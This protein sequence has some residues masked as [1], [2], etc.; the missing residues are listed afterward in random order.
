MPNPAFF[1]AARTTAYEF[2]HQPDY[3]ALLYTTD[4]A[5]L[6]QILDDLTTLIQTDWQDKVTRAAESGLTFTPIYRYFFADTF[7]GFPIYL[8]INGPPDDPNFFITN[9]YSSVLSQLETIM[10]PGIVTNY[11]TGQNKGSKIVLNWST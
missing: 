6:Q 5:V 8:L 9:G 3:V 1:A 2:T 7:E 10:A 4:H 11:Y